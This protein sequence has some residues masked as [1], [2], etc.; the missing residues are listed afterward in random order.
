MHFVKSEA[1]FRTIFRM[2]QSNLPVIHVIHFGLQYTLFPN[3][4]DQSEIQ[5]HSVTNVSLFMM[6][7]VFSTKESDWKH[8]FE[9]HDSW[10]YTLHSLHR[11]VL[12]QG[13]LVSFPKQLFDIYLAQLFLVEWNWNSQHLAFSS[14]AN[15][16]FNL[17]L[18]LSLETWILSNTVPQMNSKFV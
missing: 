10:T 14:L 13:Q 9:I 1:I 15:V 2:W 16:M 17:S 5:T 11:Q 4:L 12:N 7:L 18:E 3:V 8:F 6:K